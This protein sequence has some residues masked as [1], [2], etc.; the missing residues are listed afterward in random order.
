MVF[1]LGCLQGTESKT[2]REVMHGRSKEAIALL[3]VWSHSIAAT[4]NLHLWKPVHISPSVP[5]RA[6]HG[7]ISKMHGR[8]DRFKQFELNSNEW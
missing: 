6:V 5:S 7:R 4:L 2:K 8:A 3:L 1:V